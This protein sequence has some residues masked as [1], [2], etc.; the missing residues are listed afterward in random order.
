MSATPVTD[1]L[2][3]AKKA[4]QDARNNK[5]QL[6]LVVGKDDPDLDTIASAVI[7]A[8]FR[9]AFPPKDPW[10][11]WYIPIVNESRTVLESYPMLTRALRH[12]S[13]DLHHLTTLEDL[14]VEG[15]SSGLH[16]DVTRFFFVDHNV[17]MRRQL[18]RKDGPL[19]TC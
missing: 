17:R 2:D 16:E 8:Y 11:A 5:Q 6:T 1:F 3:L 13:I 12:A 7:L 4:L 18:S 10:S 19:T 14:V 9:T 15:R